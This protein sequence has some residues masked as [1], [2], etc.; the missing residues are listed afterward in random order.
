[1]KFDDSGWTCCSQICEAWSEGVK[2]NK[3]VSHVERLLTV[4]SQTLVIKNG[5]PQE[6][7][8]WLSSNEPD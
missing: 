8:L 3:C 1:M 2:P 4:G 7:P 6:F 5:L